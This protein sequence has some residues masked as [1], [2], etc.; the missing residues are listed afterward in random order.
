M[1]KNALHTKRFNK[2][3]ILAVIPA[4]GGSKGIPGKNLTSL[5][6]KPLISYSIQAA[7]NALTV[8]RIL[9]STDDINIAKVSMDLGAEVPFLRPVHLAS[10]VAPMIGVVQH[11]LLWAQ[12]QSDEIEAVV[13]LQPTSP[14]RTSKHID[15]CVKLFRTYKPDSVVSVIEVPH[16]FNP[17]SVMSLDQNGRLISFADNKPAPTRRQ[18]KPKFYARNGPSIVVC[19][20]STILNGS[21]Y[22]INCIP[23]LMAS[24]D[25]V[26][27]DEPD[28]IALV[29]KIFH[30]KSAG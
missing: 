8:D 21:L 2:L 3:S 15:D 13:L 22:G 20:P 4:R 30:S 9:V 24:E 5:S 19:H 6:G 26:D 25:S 17:L 29:E 11:A 1:C 28:D 23:Y 12:E 7:L 18:D 27:I 10:D 16:Q 14:L